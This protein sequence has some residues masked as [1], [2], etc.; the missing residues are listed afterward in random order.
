MPLNSRPVDQ[1][2]FTRVMLVSIE[3]RLD[4]ET[5]V[6]FTSKDGTERKWTVQVVAS[7]P[8]RWDAGRTD[9]EVLSVT[10]TC[11]EDPTQQIAEGDQVQFAN[12][13]VGV[14]D[15]VQGE[16]GRIRG[17][18]LFDQATGVRPAGGKS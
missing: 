18:K 3:P 11:K 12:W 9:S 7:L 10:V 15:P 1:A 5:G 2:A 13:T 4:R 16:S 17:G 6:Q 8:S 14:M